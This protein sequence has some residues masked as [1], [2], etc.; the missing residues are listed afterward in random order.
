MQL[1]TKGKTLQLI[2]IKIFG[3]INIE[4]MKGEKI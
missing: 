1:L 3:I 2:L 4:K